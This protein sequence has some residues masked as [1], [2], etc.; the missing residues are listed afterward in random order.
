MSTRGRR[1]SLIPILLGVCLVVPAGGSWA[2]EC[3][4]SL[5]STL[6]KEEKDG[7]IVTYMFKVDVKSPARCA[8]VK[9]VLK[10]VEAVTGEEDRTKKIPHHT[11][12]RDGYSVSAKVSYRLP[13][14]RRLVSWKFETV[15]CQPCGAAKS[16]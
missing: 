7:E 11:R 13:A 12:V 14:K 9:Y 8:D 15:S 16:D 2:D 3:Q 1:S 4:A 10:V 6:M 5:D